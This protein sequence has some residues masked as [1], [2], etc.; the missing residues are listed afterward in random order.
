VSKK[1]RRLEKI[2][3]KLIEVEIEMGSQGIRMW[4][5]FSRGSTGVLTKMYQG[6]GGCL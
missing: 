6:G 1:Q 4:E 5:G 2:R 3:E